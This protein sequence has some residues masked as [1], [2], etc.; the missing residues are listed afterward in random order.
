MRIYKVKEPA[1]RVAN[2]DLL[3]QIR[4]KKS[5]HSKKGKKKQGVIN[6]KPVVVKGKSPAIAASAK[7]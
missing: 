3:R 5:V 4:R 2:K 6:N 7:K 1:N